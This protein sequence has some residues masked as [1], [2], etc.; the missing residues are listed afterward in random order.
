M[1]SLLP[2]NSTQLERAA[3]L[4]GAR[5]S[6]LAVIT[7]E[8]WNAES[9]PAELLP[10][11]AWAW[12]VDAWQND[13]SERQ[14]RDTIKQAIAVQRVKGT[15]GAVRQALAALGVPARVQEWFNQSPAG[16]PYTFRLLLEIDQQ[17]L[18]QSGIS[19]I[20]EVVEITKNLR[21]HLETVLQSVTSRTAINTAVAASLGNDL[22]ITY[23]APRYSNGSPALDLLTDAAEYG[24]TSTV[25]AIDSLNTLLHSRLTSSY[26]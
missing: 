13:W 6:D 11:L 21:S 9:C 25:A 7:R 23:D 22:N 12:S 20:L 17:P 14:K 3:V 1:S 19:K 16:A 4:A 10:W 2:I 5:I 18:P 15:I 8:I 26:W 24:M